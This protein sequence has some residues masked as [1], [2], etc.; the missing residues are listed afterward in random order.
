MK[1]INHYEVVI[2]LEKGIL[3][4]DKEF[5]QEVV[6]ILAENE[7]RLCLNDLRF[8]TVETGGSYVGKEL[9]KPVIQIYNK[10]SCFGTMI[11]Y[12]LYTF[13][14]KRPTTIRKEIQAEVDK[15]FGIFAG[16]IDLSFIE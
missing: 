14:K 16:S 8:T 11:R 15:K 12:E 4:F 2:P 10:D 6:E 13:S 3:D 7:Y 1:T 9:G 5:K